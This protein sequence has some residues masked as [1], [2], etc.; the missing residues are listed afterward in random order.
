MFVLKPTWTVFPFTTTQA[1]S[2]PPFLRLSAFF[3]G[4]GVAITCEGFA[5]IWG[6]PEAALGKG[7]R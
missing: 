1:G 6:S 7:P 4:S 3:G 2:V 5:R